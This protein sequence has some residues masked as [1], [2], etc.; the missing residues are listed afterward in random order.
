MQTKDKWMIGVGLAILVYGV[1]GDTT[2]YDPEAGRTYDSVVPIVLGIAMI[3][4]S[5]FRK[6]DRND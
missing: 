1:V 4:Y 5:I 3:A 2:I 6:K